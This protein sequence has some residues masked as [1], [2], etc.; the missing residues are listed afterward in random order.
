MSD[1]ILDAVQ[2]HLGHS[3]DFAREM[4]RQFPDDDILNLSLLAEIDS[5]LSGVLSEW[6]TLI[7][8]EPQFMTAE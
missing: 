5:S 3:H 2:A 1:S 6:R 7:A 4:Q 8:L